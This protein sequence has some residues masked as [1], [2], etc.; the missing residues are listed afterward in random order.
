M[1]H[2]VFVW[3]ISDVI[4]AVFLSAAAILFAG[5]GAMLLADKVWHKATG[6]H[7]PYNRRKI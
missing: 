7:L 6:R 2:W 3:T 5:L 1:P 4:A